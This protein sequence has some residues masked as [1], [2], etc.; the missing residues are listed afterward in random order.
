MKV[1]MWKRFVGGDQANQL[2]PSSALMSEHPVR[3]ASTVYTKRRLCICK[4]RI[5]ALCDQKM[6]TASACEATIKALMRTHPE[7]MDKEP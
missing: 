1:L 6:T 7:T 5:L 3:L 2:V 4:Q